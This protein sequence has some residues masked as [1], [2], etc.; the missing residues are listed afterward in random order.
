MEA[1]NVGSRCWKEYQ[2]GSE[3]GHFTFIHTLRAMIHN[4]SPLVCPISRY[5]ILLDSWHASRDSKMT[6]GVSRTKKNEVRY[7]FWRNVLSEMEPLRFQAPS[8]KTKK[9]MGALYIAPL[10]MFINPWIRHVDMVRL[11]ARIHWWVCFDWTV[12]HAL[13]VYKLIFY[14]TP[15]RKLEDE[16][17][18]GP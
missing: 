17:Q 3:V 14:S 9:N 12:Q 18:A 8:S 6:N 5:S 10:P 11:L 13:A 1:K 15:S 7:R 2:R 16:S 4:P